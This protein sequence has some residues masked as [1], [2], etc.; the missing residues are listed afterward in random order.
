MVQAKGRTLECVLI[1]VLRESS[2]E[3]RFRQSAFIREKIVN[4][5]LYVLRNENSAYLAQSRQRA[6]HP[7]GCAYGC[8]FCVASERACWLAD[9]LPIHIGKMA[10]NAP[11]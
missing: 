5:K 4:K 2:R 7:Y 10:D 3:N 6:A 1:W 8:A 9:N 11:T